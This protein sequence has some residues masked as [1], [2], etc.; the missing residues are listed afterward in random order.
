MDDSQE[1]V[2]DAYVDSAPQEEMFGEADEYEQ[3]EIQYDD[4][5][6]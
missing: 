5:M 6:E 4:N 1:H 2:D 3:E